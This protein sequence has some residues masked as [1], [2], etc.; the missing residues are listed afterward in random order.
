VARQV[1]STQ[2][3]PRVAWIDSR[4]IRNTRTYTSVAKDCPVSNQQRRFRCK[5]SPVTPCQT[6]DMTPLPELNPLELPRSQPN[7]RE[8][9]ITF[10]CN[11]KCDDVADS[12]LRQIACNERSMPPGARRT[13]DNDGCSNQR[14]RGRRPL[15]RSAHG[16]TLDTDPSPATLFPNDPAADPAGPT[17][18]VMRW[19]SVGIRIHLSHGTAQAARIVFDWLY[20]TILTADLPT[21]SR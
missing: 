2:C 14:K 10:T 12:S 11:G 17:V 5:S 3:V 19:W 7:D 6:R 8:H 9:L 16:S 4:S 20:W 18:A 21:R 15:V 13:R 1:S